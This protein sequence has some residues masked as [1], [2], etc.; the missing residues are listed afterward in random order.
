MP[1]RSESSTPQPLLTTLAF[2]AAVHACSYLVQLMGVGVYNTGSWAEVRSSVFV[3]EEYGECTAQVVCAW[4]M[5]L[6]AKCCCAQKPGPTRSPD[7]LEMFAMLVDKTLDRLACT[8]CILQL[9]VSMSS[10][11][12]THMLV[13]DGMLAAGPMTLAKLLKA[14]QLHPHES[15]FLYTYIDAIK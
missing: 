1:C 7:G 8:A 4:V 10:S 3:V 13:P 11:T 15:V 5:R 2:L 6:H 14:L 12:G 9:D